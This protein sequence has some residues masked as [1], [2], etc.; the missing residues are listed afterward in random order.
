MQ[1]MIDNL[2]VL[3]SKDQ[4]LEDVTLLLMENFHYH[5]KAFYANIAKF[6]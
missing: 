5:W 4:I 2:A 3:G 6:G 1:C